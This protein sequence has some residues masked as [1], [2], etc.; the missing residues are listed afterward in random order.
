M[1]SARL[2]QRSSVDCQTCRVYRQQQHQHPSAPGTSSAQRAHPDT[3]KAI[4][5]EATMQS[6]R[7]FCIESLIANEEKYSGKL[8]RVEDDVDEED[9]EEEVA[10]DLSDGESPR[11]TQHSTP[12]SVNDILNPEKFTTTYKERCSSLVAETED[13]HKV[14]WHPWMS[15]TRYNRPQKIQGTIESPSTSVCVSLYLYHSRTLHVDT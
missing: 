4:T 11:T 1:K 8:R 5:S 2:S 7:S 3:S 13:A 6:N 15:A 10:S 12:F 14:V 9:E